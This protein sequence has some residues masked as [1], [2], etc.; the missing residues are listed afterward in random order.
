M[1]QLDLLLDLVKVDMSNGILSVENLRNLLE[2]RALGL[3]VDEV[4]PD[5]LNEVPELRVHRVSP[6]RF[7]QR[8]KGKRWAGG[9][10]TV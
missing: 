6:R 5:E 9:L 2:S 4:D 1:A 10:L 8:G 3:H 7:L